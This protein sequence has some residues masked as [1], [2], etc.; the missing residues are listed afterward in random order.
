MIE[1]DTIRP[2]TY[3][4]FKEYYT[5]YNN[6]AELN[7]LYTQYLSEYNTFSEKNKIDKNLYTTNLY[8]EFIKS[9]D[10]KIFFN[11]IS[12]F[13][14]NL[15]YDD[16]YE[17]DI[18]IHY[19]SYALKRE[20]ISL[21]KKRDN[22][23]LTKTKNKFKV[24][25]KGIELYIKNLIVNLLYDYYFSKTNT[26]Q[27][28]LKKQKIKEITY[29]LKVKFEQLSTERSLVTESVE[30]NGQKEFV[31][32]ILMDFNNKL[33]PSSNIENTSK[34][35]L[36]S[37][38][39]KDQN[40]NNRILT[41][42][43]NKK[44]SINKIYSDYNLLPERYFANEIKTEENLIFNINDKLAEKY[45]E[46]DTY[47]LS[48]DSTS[49]E[50]MKLHVAENKYKNVFRYNPTVS[51]LF[52]EK[53]IHNDKIPFQL[54][55][56]NAGLAQ[57]LSKDI[58]FS[59]NVSAISGEFILPDI[60]NIQSGVGF[61]SRK[62]NK[63]NILNYSANNSF[64]KN[65]D[66]DSASVF[67]NNVLKNYGYQ[68]KE[69][70]I[71]YNHTGINKNTDEISFWE[72]NNQNI[73]K[74]KDV[75]QRSN[76]NKFPE[77]ERLQDLLITNSTAVEIKNDIYGNEFIMYKNAY[78]KRKTKI[79]LPNDYQS[80]TQYDVTNNPAISAIS[81]YK[82]KYELPGELFVRDVSSQKVYTFYEKLSSV[83]TKLPVDLQNS[84]KN[85]EITTFDIVGNTLF[86]QTS[87]YTFTESYTYDG[88]NFKLSV[89]SNSLI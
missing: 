55:Y 41:N 81:L 13:L 34:S 10:K 9:I 82:Q 65:N 72:G 60:Y 4:E 85:N 1:L 46:S 84:I 3:N 63:H 36:Q 87:A 52:T 31:S 23:K 2:H 26:L 39:I 17:L 58:T 53:K 67:D 35:V 11:E 64:F 83:F 27:T 25:K 76:F 89:A 20:C 30:T 57:L 32:S 80:Q 59:V 21:Q 54:S 40:N 16:P 70:S 12:N 14:E 86:I 77:N 37:L 68:S 75:Y 45:L 7:S 73:W 18:A 61:K 6:P 71:K 62:N 42:N 79:P 19:I 43:K 78:P 49:Y 29:K 47:Y 88:T 5:D 74:N 69:S 22:L 44:I 15:D 51:N 66:R 28:N 24:S 38:R 56:N 50:I 48:G 8:K 33:K